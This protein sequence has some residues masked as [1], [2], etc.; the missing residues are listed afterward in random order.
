MPRHKPVALDYRNLVLAKVKEKYLYILLG[1][2]VILIILSSLMLVF[3]ATVIN[4]SEK[5]NK[6]VVVK[7]VNNQ[8]QKKY[9]VKEGDYLWKIAEETYGSGFNAY[10][11]AKV[12]N[13]ANPSLI[14]PGQTLIIPKVKPL[15]PTKG[16]IAEAVTAKVTYTGDKYTINK[17]DYLWKIALEAYGDGY[18][19]VKIAKANNLENP[20][21]IHVGNTLVLPR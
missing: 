5:P 8:E 1:I 4:V 12:N 7:E 3:K 21:L 11:I 13:I 18:A 15:Q 2:G 6:S 19:W 20:D 10:D 16:E 14:E 9:L 17:G